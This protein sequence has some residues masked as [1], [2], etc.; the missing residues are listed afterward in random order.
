MANLP[1]AY[2]FWFPFL[3]SFIFCAIGI[4]VGG[5]IIAGILQLILK[6]KHKFWTLFNIASLVITIGLHIYFYFP[7]LKIIVPNNFAGEINLIV[8]P[9]NE[10]N[11][12]IDSNGTGYITESIYID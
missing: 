8:H 10:K 7:P 3:L 1:S 5:I 9:D 11:L 2:G 4:G 12:T 6:K